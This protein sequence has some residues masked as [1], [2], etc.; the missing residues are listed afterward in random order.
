M[1]RVLGFASKNWSLEFR[2]QV[3]GIGVLGLRFKV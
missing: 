1:F 2:V 3:L